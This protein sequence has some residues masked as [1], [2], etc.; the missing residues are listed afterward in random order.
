MNARLLRAGSCRSRGRIR[1]GL[2]SFERKP[3]N[4]LRPW[5]WLQS[6]HDNIGVL[7]QFLT[8]TLFANMI[9]KYYFDPSSRA[10][11]SSNFYTDLFYLFRNFH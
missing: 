11:H 10:H 6:N 2:L 4:A 1:S 3:C 8:L 5:I 9:D 7:Y